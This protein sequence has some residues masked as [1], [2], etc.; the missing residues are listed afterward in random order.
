MKAKWVSYLEE[1]ELGRGFVFL[2]RGT[3]KRHRQVYAEFSPSEME[4]D[5]ETVDAIMQEAHVI[6]HTR[7]NEKD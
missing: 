5:R 4:D 1:D 7:S 2:Q 3:D 6:A